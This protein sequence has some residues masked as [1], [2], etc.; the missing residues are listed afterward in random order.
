MGEADDKPQYI[1]MTM[2][3]WSDLG[4]SRIDESRDSEWQCPNCKHRV[5]NLQMERNSR[6]EECWGCLKFCDTVDA[7]YFHGKACKCYDKGDSYYCWP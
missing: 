7:S 1:A 2:E 3:Q 6:G 4:K 5:H